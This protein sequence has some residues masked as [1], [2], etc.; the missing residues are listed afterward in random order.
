MR[1][2]PFSLLRS[3]SPSR[4]LKASAHADP[5]LDEEGP[6]RPRGGTSWLPWVI[7]PLVVPPDVKPALSSHQ[8]AAGVRS[9]GSRRTL[10]PLAFGLSA[11]ALALGT[12]SARAD[13]T[14]KDDK[15]AP[16]FDDVKPLLTK[17]CTTCH[18]GEK[19]RA[20]MA[21]DSYRDEKSALKERK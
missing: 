13:E 21:L 7:I 14:K 16:K 20:G 8:L 1:L 15:S 6:S 3:W 19:P 11:L 5:A 17:Y 2:S 4:N 18:G 10:L 12:G 9:M